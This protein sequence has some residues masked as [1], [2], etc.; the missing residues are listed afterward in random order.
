MPNADAL[1]EIARR[2]ERTG[3]MRYLTPVAVSYGA[4]RPTTQRNS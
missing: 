1:T 4:W 3:I 2:N